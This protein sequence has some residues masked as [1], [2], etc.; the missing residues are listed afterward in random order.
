[1][2][3]TNN[4]TKRRFELK[5]YR[6]RTDK[7]DCPACGMSHRFSE[8]IDVLTGLPVGSGMG[9]CDRVNH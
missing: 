2:E 8:Y 9:K 1:M 7:P 5:S 3:L 6:H 4:N